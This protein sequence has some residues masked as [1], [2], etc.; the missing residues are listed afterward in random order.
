MAAKKRSSRVVSRLK[1][2]CIEVRT[3]NTNYGNPRRGWMC[4]SMKG[5]F[6]GFVD[7]GYEGVGALRA[8]F[9]NENR[10]FPSIG[11]TPKEYNAL[12]KKAVNKS[13]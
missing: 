12:K 5:R 10:V 6:M 13:R 8:S 11:I 3:S 9:P 1:V 2:N 4:W 7:S